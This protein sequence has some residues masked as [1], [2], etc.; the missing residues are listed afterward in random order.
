M[1]YYNLME[2]RMSIRDFKDWDLSEKQMEDIREH[3][4]KGSRLIPHIDVDLVLLQKEGEKLLDGVAGY[5]GFLIKAPYYLLILSEDHP[6]A[7]QNAGYIGEDL[8]LKLSEMELDSCWVTLT[9]SDAVKEAVGLSSD[10]NVAAIIAFG[11]GNSLGDRTRLDIKSPSDIH[12]ITREGHLAPKI[13]VEDLV[14]L[15]KWGQKSGWEEDV[16]DDTMEKA[17]YGASIAPS[18]LN[19]QPYRFIYDYNQ[20]ILAVKEDELTGEHDGKPNQGIVM[21]H[22]SAVLSQWRPR[23]VQW[24]MGA[25]DKTYEIPGEYEIAG[26]CEV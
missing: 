8:V 7:A 19:R 6:Y 18:F 3:F 14:Y 24:V 4:Q 26:Y 15:E 1:D 11:Y 23:E 12:V 10:K 2:K 17:F 5:K 22:F 16:I 21:F 20:M 9:D 25:P 13:C